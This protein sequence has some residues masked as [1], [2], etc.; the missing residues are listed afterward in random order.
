MDATTDKATT[1]KQEASG[2]IGFAI[3]ALEEAQNAITNVE[4]TGSADIYSEIANH[5]TALRELKDRVDDLK[6]TGFFEA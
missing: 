1:L 6:P 3:R 4:G 5:Y 2:K